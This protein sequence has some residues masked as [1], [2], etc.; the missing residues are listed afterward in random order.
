MRLF[1]NILL[2][3]LLIAWLA[4]RGRPSSAPAAR[5]RPPTVDN[6]FAN[7]LLHGGDEDVPACEA[8]GSRVFEA[9]RHNLLSDATDIFLTRTGF[10][11]FSTTSS[12]THPNKRDPEKF[13]PLLSGCKNDNR[14]CTK[15]PYHYWR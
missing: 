1:A 4:P 9:Y 3:L 8:E 7:P 2:L 11:H 10:A 12:T 14:A 6:P 15:E 13:Y 5:C